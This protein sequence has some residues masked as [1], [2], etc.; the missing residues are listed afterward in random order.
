[1]K[2]LGHAVQLSQIRGKGR[3]RWKWSVQSIMCAGVATSLQE[4][5]VTALEAIF[6]W[7][8]SPHNYKAFQILAKMTGHDFV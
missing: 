5:R 4:A 7:L 6:R 3:S 8:G 2:R 1:L